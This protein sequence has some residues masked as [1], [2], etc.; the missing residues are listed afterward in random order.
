MTRTLCS[1]LAVVAVLALFAGCPSDKARTAAWQ[2]WGITGPLPDSAA[3][4]LLAKAYKL[5]YAQQF[6]E[7]RALYRRVADS[8]PSSA[9]ARLGLSMSLRYLGEL[10][11]AWAESEKAMALDSAAA[12][13]LL[14]HA[15]LLAPHRGL[16]LPGPL[17]E[18]G[19][20]ARGN[21][22]DLRAAALDHPLAAYGRTQLWTNNMVEGRLPEARAQLVELGRAGYFPPELRDMAYNMLVAL[23]PDAILFT[24]G[25]N[26]TYPL[27][28]LQEHE[29]FRRDVAVVNMSL[30]NLPSVAALMRDSF[31]VPISYTD[32]GLD[33]LRPAKVGDRVVLPA[34]LVV[35]SI[36]AGAGA[37]K[38]PVY[39]A[40]T[41]YR[42]RWADYADRMVVE[43][44]VFGVR[45]D[46]VREEVDFDRVVE[47]MTGRYRLGNVA[48]ET[49]WPA[50]LSPVT[51]QTRFLGN[52]YAALYDRMAGH[53]RE[54]GD[55]AAAGR[56]LR[57]VIRIAGFTGNDRMAQAARDAE[58]ELGTG[59]N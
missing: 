7:A 52:N 54:A 17:D 39:F 19:R 40:L 20:R 29:G 2:R 33:S 16:Q 41:A 12:G 42:D 34:D 3:E 32:A 44:L 9:E 53:Y 21:E 13:V 25:D 26:D 15:D 51:R 43:G 38:R 11:R 57:E 4:A 14:N 5:L 8:F 10:D 30:L 48:V 50:N 49:P 27:W 23:E 22:L 36:V 18:R 28:T 45:D 55:T 59:G 58:A 1:I 35:A 37:A 24:N 47:N 56:C 6:D 31:A 46:R